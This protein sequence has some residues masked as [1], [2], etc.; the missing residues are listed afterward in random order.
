MGIE[1]LTQKAKDFAA[2]NGEKINE[3][4]HSEQAEQISDRVLDG[5]AKAAN[6]VT[7]DKYADKVEELRD[8]ADKKLGNEE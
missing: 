4:L 2:K 5:L 3:A 8:S 1:D 7:G 6:T